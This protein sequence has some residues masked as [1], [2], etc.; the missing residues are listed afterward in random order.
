MYHFCWWLFLGHCCLA[1]WHQLVSAI[2]S[3][4]QCFI[5]FVSQLRFWAVLA[6][7]AVLVK[8]EQVDFITEAHWWDCDL[9]SYFALAGFWQAF[10]EIRQS[11]NFMVLLSALACTSW[12][13][14][15]SVEDFLGTLTRECYNRVGASAALQSCFSFQAR[16]SPDPC[17]D[18]QCKRLNPEGP[19]TLRNLGSK[20]MI[21]MAFG[22]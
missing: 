15:K 1:C 18:N 12:T 5:M 9:R 6:A 19:G 17:K 3:H 2:D 8:I 21:I 7:L 10:K 22:A 4:E 14:R 20:T 11:S 13:F 16:F